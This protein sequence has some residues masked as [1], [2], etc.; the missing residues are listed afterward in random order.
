MDCGHA[1]GPF[2]ITI[3]DYP[4]LM[5]FTM[6]LSVSLKSLDGFLQIFLHFSGQMYY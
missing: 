5:S 2:T 1:G 3:C 4:E 6:N